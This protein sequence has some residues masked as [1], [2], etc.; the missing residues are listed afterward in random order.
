[1]RALKVYHLSNHFQ[2]RDR[3]TFLPNA[4]LQE[5]DGKPCTRYDFRSLRRTS[6]NKKVL[7]QHCIALKS[8]TD[9]KAPWQTIDSTNSILN[10]LTQ[11]EEWIWKKRDTILKRK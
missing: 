2:Y 4:Y 1:M 10:A 11:T 5:F 6:C 7:I 8:K 3:K 9:N